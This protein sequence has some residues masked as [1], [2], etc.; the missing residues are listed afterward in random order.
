MRQHCGGSAF[1]STQKPCFCAA[2]LLGFAVLPVAWVLARR[3]TVAGAV[4]W[5]LVAGLQPGVMVAWASQPNW[6]WVVFVTIE[7]ITA[8]VFLWW[9]N[10][11][12]EY[13]ETA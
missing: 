12:S 1:R 5:G 8:S 7:G 3:A 13:W 4:V 10:L 11:D 9:R 6:Q 2:Y